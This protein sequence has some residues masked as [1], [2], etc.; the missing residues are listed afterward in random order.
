MN[1]STDHESTQDAPDGRRRRRSGG[2][3]RACLLGAWPTPDVNEAHYLTKAKH[4][5]QPHWC[6][7]DLFLASGES[8]VTY[9]ATFGYL[10]QLMSFDAA[11]WCGRLAGWLMLAIGWRRLSFVFALKDRHGRVVRGGRVCTQSAISDV[12][13]M[14]RRRH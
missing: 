14:V 9:Y 13:R 11:A 5:W 3:R 6:A 8:H 1:L 4:F 10:T 2:V 12:G 7:N